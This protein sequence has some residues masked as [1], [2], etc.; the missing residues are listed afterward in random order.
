M[1]PGLENATFVRFGQIHRNTFINSPTHL[2]RFYR[3]KDGRR[4]CAWPAR[5][6]ASRGTSN[7]R[8]PASPIGLYLALERRGRGPD[9]VPGHHR[10]SGAL[11]RHL[12]ESDPRHFQP[13][14]V[15]Y[16]LFEEL[17]GRSARRTAV[18]P[19]SSGLIEIS[20][21][22]CGGR[23]RQRREPGSRPVRS[24]VRRRR[25]DCRGRLSGRRR[26]RP[27]GW[28]RF[29]GHDSPPADPPLLGA[30]RAT[31]GTP[32]RTRSRAYERRPA[33]LPRLPRPRLPG[34][35][36]RTRSSPATSTPLAVRSFLA[37][38]HRAGLASSS[39][40]RA[41][42]AVR[43]LFRFA[44]REGALAANPAQAVRTPKAPKHLP[45]HLRPGEVEGLIEAEPAPGDG[46]PLALRDRALLE[47]LYASGPA[48]ERAGG[49]RL[50]EHRPLGARAAGAW[51]RAARSAWSPSAGPRRRRCAPGW[52]SGRRCAGRRRRPRRSRCS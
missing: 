7:R 16:G 3:L 33:S 19:T 10:R 48:G 18:P 14:N 51:A 31:S 35:G 29:P 17:P 26:L 28:R 6:P 20:G 30:P 39:Q 44:C 34:Q 52:R 8:R 23:L 42:A 4:G 11:A 5:S 50:A 37:Y 38:L 43:S 32:R 1:I 41:L 2:D 22:G 27:L 9:A 24:G 13:A 45:R 49:P 12:T 36:S 15:N 40:G 25:R 47:L 21:R 46:N